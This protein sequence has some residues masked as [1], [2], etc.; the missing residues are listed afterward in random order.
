VE[1]TVAQFDYTSFR[2]HLERFVK[3]ARTKS[4]FWGGKCWTSKGML[5]ELQAAM[6]SM[7]ATEKRLLGETIDKIV[8]SAVPK[9]TRRDGG[10]PGFLISCKELVR[11]QR[12]LRNEGLDWKIGHYTKGSGGGDYWGI[13][14]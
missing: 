9:T 5:E 13:E 14:D 6:P 10:S 8:A 12:I 11:L 2:D 3:Y 7:N 1:S 4:T